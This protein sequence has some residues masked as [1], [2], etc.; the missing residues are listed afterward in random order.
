VDHCPRT[1]TG[2]L[3]QQVWAACVAHSELLELGCCSSSLGYKLHA[4][5]V[6]P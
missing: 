5:G 4:R 2:A 1:H 6:L 3:V